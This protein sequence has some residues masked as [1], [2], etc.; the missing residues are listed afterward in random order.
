MEVFH[1]SVF[2]LVAPPV[3]SITPVIAVKVDRLQGKNELVF[4]CDF[5]PDTS[6]NYI[7]TIG[8]FLSSGLTL[9]T[10]LHTSDPTPYNNKIEFRS[11]TALTETLLK[12]R[13]IT[14][15]GFRVS[16]TFFSAVFYTYM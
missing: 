2:F 3:L 4:Y 15:V 8:W 6:K 9:T 14:K 11:R 10:H 5:K 16:H 1:F 7:Y 12:E 13:G